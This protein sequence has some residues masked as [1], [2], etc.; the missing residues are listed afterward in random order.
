MGR[1]PHLGAFELEGADDVAIARDALAATG[2][3]SLARRP[4]STLS[5]GEKQR[6][7]HRGGAGAGRPTC[8]CSTSRRRRSTSAYQLDIAALLAALNRDRGLTMVLST[9]DLNFA[10]AVCREL[11]LLAGGAVLAGGRPADVLH[12][13]PTCSASTASTPTSDSTSSAGHLTVRR[14]DL[15]GRR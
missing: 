3:G 8:C 1:Y 2:T 9:H 14:A 10:A 11:V 13:P 15:A 4:F 5:G 6:V 7:V 12:R